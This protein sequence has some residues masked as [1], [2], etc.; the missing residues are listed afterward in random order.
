MAHEQEQARR[1]RDM[2]LALVGIV[3]PL[4]SLSRLQTF[5]VTES[6]G[7]QYDQ[8]LMEFLL[9]LRSEMILVIRTVK[10]VDAALVH[11]FD[12]LAESYTPYAV[13]EKCI[14]AL[15]H[16]MP[17]LAGSNSEKFPAAMR[18]MKGW[19][20]LFPS[21]TRPPLPFAAALVMAAI[22]VA[23]GLSTMGLALLV[24]FSAYL[25]P[26]ELTSLRTAQ[27]IMP[28]QSGQTHFRYPALLL[29]RFEGLRPGKTGRFDESIILDSH[30]MAGWIT[31]QLEVLLQ[32][33]AP[34]DP[35]WP[36]THAEF[37]SQY[38]R[39]A[40]DFGLKTRGL[41]V[42]IYGLR[43]G[44]ASHDTLAELRTFEQVKERGRWACDRSVHRFRKA[45]LAQAEVQKLSRHHQQLAA[46]IAKDPGA[47]FT[48]GAL[49][50]D[51]LP[52]LEL[53]R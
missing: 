52:Q 43:H 40:E 29:H 5:A 42:A 28:Q 34:S 39:A 41:N 50:R 4:S 46:R 7:V 44:G 26:S 19:R 13:G 36:F 33:K 49:R 18:A 51:L 2:T 3:L 45:S 1:L 48:S 27:V 9:W 15:A 25:R 24:G 21:R 22:L 14:A 38:R 37:L 10:G 8:A 47:L 17:T 6:V 23:R 11:Y 53:G 16:R 30:W 32:S 20:R 35:V 31:N 12:H